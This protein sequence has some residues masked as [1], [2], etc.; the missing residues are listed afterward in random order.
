VISLESGLIRTRTI[1]LGRRWM[2]RYAISSLEPFPKR[3]TSLSIRSVT[4]QGGVLSCR[5]IPSGASVPNEDKVATSGGCRLREF[6][7]Q[8]A[9]FS[10]LELKARRARQL[11]TLFARSVA[12]VSRSAA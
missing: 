12:A 4:L 7:P 6:V 9:L 3:S 11:K 8:H 5:P 1:A 2:R 10:E